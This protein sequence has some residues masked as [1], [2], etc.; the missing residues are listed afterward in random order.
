M[1]PKKLVNMLRKPF[2]RKSA[3]SSPI[4][5]PRTRGR[6]D[7]GSRSEGSDPVGHK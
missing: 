4:A 5:P 1:G 2:R 6:R 7:S 3:P